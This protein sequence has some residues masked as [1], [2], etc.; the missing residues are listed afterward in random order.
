MIVCL[1]CSS[2]GNWTPS[3][4]GWTQR[5]SRWR[6]TSTLCGVICGPRSSRSPLLILA[7]T[8]RRRRPE[9]EHSI[10]STLDVA[11]FFLSFIRTHSCHFEGETWLFVSSLVDSNYLV[12]KKTDVESVFNLFQNK[13][14]NKT[15]IY[16]STSLCQ[17][18]SVSFQLKICP[19]LFI[20]VAPR[21]AVAGISA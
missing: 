17:D 6:P 7:P 2:P 14:E 13:E 4:T 11:H 18:T 15:L 19:R 8:R 9:N 21:I 5:R 12:L 16:V 20:T 3:W 1:S 10:S